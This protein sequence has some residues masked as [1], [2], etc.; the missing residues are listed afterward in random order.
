MAASA[1]RIG[2][3]VR[4]AARRAPHQVGGYSADRDSLMAAKVLERLTGVPVEIPKTFA[5]LQGTAREPEARLLYSMVRGVEVEEVGPRPAP[6][7]SRDRTPRPTATSATRGPDRDQMPDARRAPR[8]AAR[9]RRSAT[10]TSSRCS[11]RW[12]APAATG[13]T[14]VRFNPDFPA[15]DAVLDQAR[16]SRPTLHRRAGGRDHS[17]HQGAGGEGRQALAPLRD[18]GMTIAT[19][20]LSPLIPRSACCIT[21]TALGDM[22]AFTWNGEAMIPAR[23]KPADKEFVSGRATGWRRR[24]SGAGSPTSIS[25]PGSARPGAICPRASPRLSRRPSICARRR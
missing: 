25:S 13:A 8:H 24:A 11:G 6:V 16:R 21:H 19:T 1:L 9:A 15:R 18:G 17:I 23:P 7:R 2:W 20:G 14:Y 22:M 12:P 4:C 5:M 10:T 3:R